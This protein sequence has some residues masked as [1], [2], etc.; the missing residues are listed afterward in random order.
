MHSAVLAVPTT[1]E[2][3]TGLPLAADKEQQQT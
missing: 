1:D 3:G 2:Y